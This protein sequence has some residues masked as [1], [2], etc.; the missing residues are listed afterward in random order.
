MNRSHLIPNTHCDVSLVVLVNPLLFVCPL[1]MVNSFVKKQL[2][3]Q[4]TI[5]YVLVCINVSSANRCIKLGSKFQGLS[6]RYYQGQKLKPVI[7]KRSQNGPKLTTP[8]PDQTSYMESSP[9]HVVVK[10]AT[11]TLITSSSSLFNT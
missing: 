5:H 7:K 3:M 6:T 2:K 8:N 10:W 4:V 11:T 1:M 9:F